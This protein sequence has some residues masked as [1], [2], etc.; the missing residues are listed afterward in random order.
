MNKSTIF[1]ILSIF[2]FS[3]CSQNDDY[4]IKLS[5]ADKEKINTDKLS[6][7]EKELAFNFKT[8][9]LPIQ[10][11]NL[12][13][14]QSIINIFTKVYSSD[15]TKLD[16]I[17][18]AIQ[19]PSNLNLWNVFK[20]SYIFSHQ[21]L[22]DSIPF[23]EDFIIN[24]LRNPDFLIGTSTN[25]NILELVKD[26]LSIYL[27]DKQNLS[28]MWSKQ[29]SDMNGKPLYYLYAINNLGQNKS[30]IDEQNI[31]DIKVKTTE[32]GEIS[33]VI[34]LD[35]IGKEEF[36]RMTRIAANN[37]NVIAIEIDNQIFSAPMV[38]S[39]ITGGAFSVTSNFDANE[40]LMYKSMLEFKKVSHPLKLISIE[41]MT[42]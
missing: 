42:N 24:D 21:E 37:Y 22:I 13:E 30:Y 4:I 1:L 9:G 35:E 25:P 17:K 32:Y 27:K 28:L 34:S 36:T 33:I 2:M 7:L 10:D 16:V 14:S 19:G 23:F 29:N 31:Q 15:S 11:I 12:D 41:K 18:N 39:E 5:L 26:S 20:N 3:A 8:L 40:A 38:R 6:V